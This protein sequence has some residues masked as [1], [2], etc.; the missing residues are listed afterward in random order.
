MEQAARLF[1]G[2]V[3]DSYVAPTGVADL[4]EG[5]QAIA[6]LEEAHY[7]TGHRRVMWYPIAGIAAPGAQ[8]APAEHVYDSFLDQNLQGFFK[9]FLSIPMASRFLLLDRFTS[10]LVV[11]Q[12]SQQNVPHDGSDP[13]FWAGERFF[14]TTH[15]YDPVFQVPGECDSEAIRDHILMLLSSGPE[16]FDP[17]WSLRNGEE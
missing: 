1:P 5:S 14:S 16:L 7:S 11:S 17:D 13:N 4:K 2:S 10:D 12:R 8:N 9:M 3:P 6:L 15:S